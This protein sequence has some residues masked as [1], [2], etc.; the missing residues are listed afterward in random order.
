M[1]FLV[2]LPLY[3]NKDRKLIGVLFS[4]GNRFCSDFPHTRKKIFTCTGLVIN[5][6]DLFYLLQKFVDFEI[7][8]G[9]SKSDM[10]N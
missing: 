6:L 9:F 3:R 1:R 5:M 8:V 10:F 2:S 7:T 4:F